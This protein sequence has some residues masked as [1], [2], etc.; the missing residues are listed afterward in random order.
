MLSL[1]GQ[2]SPE[3]KEKFIEEHKKH[4]IE[5][6]YNGLRTGESTKKNNE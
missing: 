1:S 2:G 6:I 5:L 4:V 3:K